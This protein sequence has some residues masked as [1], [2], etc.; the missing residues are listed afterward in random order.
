MADPNR[1]PPRKDRDPLNEDLNPPQG[2]RQRSRREPSSIAND[3][4]ER[5]RRRRTGDDEPSNDE[6]GN[7]GNIVSDDIEDEG[8]GRSDR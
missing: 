7:I 8:L 2:E 5:I 3:Q 6:V 4:G 1:T